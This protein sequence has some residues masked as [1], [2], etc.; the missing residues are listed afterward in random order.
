MTNNFI[1][2]TGNQI[3]TP[4]GAPGTGVFIKLSYQDRPKDKQYAYDKYQNE[5]DAKNIKRSGKKKVKKQ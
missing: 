3:N 5:R 1:G 4:R 2:P